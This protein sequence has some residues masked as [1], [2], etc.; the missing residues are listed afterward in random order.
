M[1]TAVLRG[2]PRAGL[3]GFVD[4]VVDTFSPA[5]GLRRR[6]NLLRAEEVDRLRECQEWNH[7][8]GAH[9][10]AKT[11]RLHSGWVSP[12]GSADADLVDDLVELRQR[13]RDLVMNDPL[14]SGLLQTLSDNIAGRGF[15]P[16]SM[17]QTTPLEGIPAATIDA[18]RKAANGAWKRWAE[19]SPDAADRQ[20]WNG[21]AGMVN[22]TTLE[23]G[24]AFSRHLMIP[25]RGSPYDLAIETLEADRVGTPAG[26]LQDSSI[27]GGVKIG[28]RGQP[29][30]WWLR[31]K[32][33]GDRVVL[34]TGADSFAF[35]RRWSKTGHEQMSQVLYQLR[36][37]QNR[38]TPAFAPCLGLFDHLAN[39]VQSEVVAA[40]VAACISMVVTKKDPLA[41]ARWRANDENDDERLEDMEPGGI[42]YLAEGESVEVVNP[43][44]PGATFDPFVVRLVRLICRGIGLPYEIGALDFSKSN[45][46]NMRAAQVETRRT[47]QCRQL[48]LGRWASVI[49]RRV[50]EEAWLDGDLPQ[51]D[52]YANFDAWMG[53]LWTMPG[54]GWVDPEKEIAASIAAIDARLSTRRRE[55]ANW[56]GQYWEDVERELLLEELRKKELEEELGVTSESKEEEDE[57]ESGG[58][59]DS[60]DTDADEED[61]DEEEDDVD[62]DGENKQQA[63]AAAHSHA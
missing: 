43:Q 18:F 8:L 60:E 10:G 59:G 14:A 53:V 35:V 4:R 36:P 26:L 5:A 57:E 12:G 2:G 25:R 21:I 24:D 50:I 41:A 40:R 52:L 61:E 56:T 9:K 22:R 19:G 32:H 15:Q 29:L 47:W 48:T 46:S 45:Y 44:R 1:S 51:V 42:E 27:R 31:T 63:V 17:P 23:S 49:Y 28:K 37:E 34:G 38:G 33:P 6:A 7:R 20:D 55:T 11:T 39:Y 62:D 58:D 16:T 30:G 54:W 13:S 3:A